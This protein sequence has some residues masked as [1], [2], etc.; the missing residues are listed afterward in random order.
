MLASSSTMEC[1]FAMIAQLATIVLLQ[2][3][4]QLSVSLDFIRIKRSRQR[5]NP[6]SL[7]HTVCLARFPARHAGPAIIVQIQQL[8]PKVAPWVLTLWLGQLL[9]RLAPMGI[10]VS[11]EKQ[12]QLHLTHSAQ[13]ASTAITTQQITINLSPAHVM[14]AFISHTEVKQLNRLV[15][16]AQLALTA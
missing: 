6:A 4:A 15:S 9:A 16:L 1:L 5:A 8:C 13:K 14:L 10:S 2:V 7:A 11:M 3:G 12:A